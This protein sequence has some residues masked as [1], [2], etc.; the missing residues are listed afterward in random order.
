MKL[1]L[2]EEKRLH[3]NKKHNGAA[4]ALLLA[5]SKGD[6]S[7]VE[8]IL[9]HARVDPNIADD[10]GRTALEWAETEGPRQDNRAL[11][12]GRPH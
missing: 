8:L 9:R 6:N 7:I 3:I 11:T 4:I 1:L 10:G 5:V 12:R 2:A